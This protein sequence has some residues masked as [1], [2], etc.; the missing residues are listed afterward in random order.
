MKQLFIL[1]LS[2]Q[3]AADVTCYTY[4]SITNC[5]NGASAYQYGN[6]TQIIPGNGQ[7]M[8]SAYTYGN[9]TQIITPTQQILPPILPQIEQLNGLYSPGFD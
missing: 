9:Q 2:F 3:A 5:S 7:P 1:L 8:I 4:G 6:V